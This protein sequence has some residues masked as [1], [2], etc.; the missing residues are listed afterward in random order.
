ML[1]IELPSDE[2]ND[3]AKVLLKYLPRSSSQ[4]GD[5]CGKRRYR[6]AAVGSIAVLGAEIEADERAQPLLAL[7]LA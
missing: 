6:A 7:Q 3:P 1:L 4:P 2:F 5:L